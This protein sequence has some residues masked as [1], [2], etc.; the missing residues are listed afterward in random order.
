MLTL[1]GTQEVDATLATERVTAGVPNSSRQGAIMY[2]KLRFRLPVTLY[3]SCSHVLPFIHLISLPMLLY[4]LM[5]CLV[6]CNMK[7]KAFFHNFKHRI[8]AL[9]ITFAVCKVLA[10]SLAPCRTG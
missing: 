2:F 8:V 5:A 9:S 6:G 7:T 1:V 4:L 10:Q 3:C